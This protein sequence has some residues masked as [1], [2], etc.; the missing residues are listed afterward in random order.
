M[1]SLASKIGLNQAIVVQQ[2]HYWLLKSRN[3]VDGRKW[4]YNTYEEWHEQFPFWSL[5]T[6]KG[7][8]AKLQ[9]QGIV[10]RRELNESNWD[11]T[12]WWSIDYEKLAPSRVQD[13]H[14]LESA[15]SAL[16]YKEQR[17]PETSSS[18]EAASPST[19]DNAKALVLMCYDT[20]GTFPQN[21]KERRKK[22]LAIAHELVEKYG[23][24]FC[25]SMIDELHKRAR[26]AKITAPIGYLRTMLE[27]QDT[28]GPAI[29]KTLV[30]DMSKIFPPED[31]KGLHYDGTG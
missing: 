23:W 18:R 14:P 9:E 17:L 31:R 26:K 8:F 27:D 12:S 16:S 21:N 3:E 29:E 4:V 22:E 1:P 19:E 2:L 11:R 15:G 7:I 24:D 30:F 13:L 5:R 6:I 20:V 25:Q 28:S 10:L